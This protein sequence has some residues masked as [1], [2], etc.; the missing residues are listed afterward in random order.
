MKAVHKA[1]KA[2][3]NEE[4]TLLQYKEEEDANARLTALDNESARHHYE[5]K[6]ANR[7]WKKEMELAENRLQDIEGPIILLKEERRQ[8]SAQLQQKLFEH[9][10]FLNARGEVKSLGQLFD[11]SENNTPPSGAGECAAPKLLQY[12]YLHGYE[13]LAMGEFWWGKTIPS[14]VRHHGRFY[15]AC[16]SKCEPIFGTHVAGIKCPPENNHRDLPS[17]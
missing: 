4:R 14:E 17:P 6:D 8:R 13:A 12:A 3:R 1:A 11:V 5:W 9:Y 15:P 16:K 2:A 7:F 10:T